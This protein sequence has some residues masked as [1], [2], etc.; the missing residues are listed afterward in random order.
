MKPGVRK[1]SD[2]S[3]SKQDASGSKRPALS[4][5]QEDGM[6]S[7]LAQ[8]AVLFACGNAQDREEV[9]AWLQ[10]MGSQVRVTSRDA[11]GDPEEWI[12]DAPSGIRMGLCLTDPITTAV[13][14]GFIFLGRFWPFVLPNLLKEVTRLWRDHKRP[15]GGQTT[16]KEQR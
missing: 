11:R 4:F 14:F 15:V 7:R 12:L 16:R 9:V 8:Q 10:Q 6:S 1:A 13:M 2:G 5:S 3:S